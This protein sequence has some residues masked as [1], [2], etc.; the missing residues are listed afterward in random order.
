MA[1]YISSHLCDRV[2]LVTTRNVD[3]L[4][5]HENLVANTRSTQSAM[6]H[7]EGVG[8]LAVPSS[9]SSVVADERPADTK[10][11]G[12]KASVL[13][14]LTQAGPPWQP[15]WQIPCGVPLVGSPL[16]DRKSF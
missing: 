9:Y 16:L 2:C 10:T 3:P 6:R 5:I 1:P 12:R 14:W 4:D 7:L 11:S 8:A 13:S 15:C